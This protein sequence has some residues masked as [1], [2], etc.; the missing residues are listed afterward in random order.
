MFGLDYSINKGDASLKGLKLAVVKD[1]TDNETGRE[2]VSVLVL[3]VHD[4]TRLDDASYD[5]IPAFHCAPSKEFSGEVPQKGDKLYGMF[6]DDNPNLFVWFGWV[7]FT[8]G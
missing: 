5:G 8:Q 7:R 1:N 6:F 2:I 4:I 3:G